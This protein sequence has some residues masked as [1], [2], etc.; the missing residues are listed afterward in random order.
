MV[1]SCLFSSITRWVNQCVCLLEGTKEIGSLAKFDFLWDNS[2]LRISKGLMRNQVRELI[3]IREK[4]KPLLS[5]S[6]LR[7][8]QVKFVGC[9]GIN[10]EYEWYALLRPRY[11][12]SY[13]LWMSLSLC[14]ERKA[15]SENT[16]KNGGI[17]VRKWYSSNVVSNQVGP[18]FCDDGFCDLYCLFSADDVVMG[19]SKVRQILMHTRFPDWL[20]KGK[21]VG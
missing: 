9:E 14:C 5:F 7:F 1:S 15:F 18:I 2:G 11:L 16:L 17:K 8:R 10:F 13:C 6:W 4:K 19:G 3:S 21:Y 12:L 20:T